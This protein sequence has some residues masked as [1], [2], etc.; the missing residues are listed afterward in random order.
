MRILKTIAVVLTLSLLLVGCG[1]TAPS[2]GTSSSGNAQAQFQGNGKPEK[3]DIT[4]GLTVPGSTYL[5]IYMADQQGYYKEQGLNV[6]VVTF[7]SGAQLAQAMAAGSVDI[8]VG[9]LSEA[10]NAIS[11]GAPLKVFYSGFNMPVFGWYSK[12]ISSFK[13]G[14]GKRFSVTSYGS[15]T[16]FLTRYALTTFGL[17]PKKD[18]QIMQTGGGGNALA[19]LDAGQIDVA[20][21][22]PPATFDAQQKGYKKILGLNDLAPEYPYHVMYAMQSFIKNDPNTIKAVL[23]AHVK[24]VETAKADKNL[25][26]KTLEQAVKYTEA[27]ASSAYDDFINYLYPDGRLP[28][29]QGMDVFWKIGIQNGQF[30]DV[31]PDD[32]WL[33]PTFINSYNQWK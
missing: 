32:K 9:A 21:L 11:S 24:A 27:E 3:T 7:K 1:S 5:P 14:K 18:V 22:A 30:K 2:T 28:N 4:I 31:W 19:A 23:R 33:D 25:S 8:G 6:K 16:D 12:D 13:D 10:L 15:S 26:V 20:I 29:K 17:D